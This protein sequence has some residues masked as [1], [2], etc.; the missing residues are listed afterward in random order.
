LVILQLS[1]CGWDLGRWD[2]VE[3]FTGVAPPRMVRR[4]GPAGL[5]RTILGRRSARERFRLD[6]SA[7]LLGHYLGRRSRDER[8]KAD[9]AMIKPE[10]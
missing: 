5:G 10:P 2:V 4:R 8:L 7:V 1:P 3:Y 9:R 6:Q